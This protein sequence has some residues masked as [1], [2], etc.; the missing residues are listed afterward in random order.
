MMRAMF[1]AA[2]TFIA[3]VLFVGCAETKTTPPVANERAALL[4]SADQ[5]MFGV[6]FNL[7]DGG[8][9]KGYVVADTAVFLN[10]NTRIELFNATVTFYNTT[11]AN[12]AVMSARYGTYHTQ[13]GLMVGRGD[14]DVKTED[15]RTLRS[16]EVKFDQRRNEISSDSAFVVTAPDRRLEGIGFRSDPNLQNVRV[17]KATSGSSGSV[18]IPNQ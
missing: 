8:I 10:S 5:V 3:A 1:L 11:G 9:A 17:L 7:T 2:S 15:G 12:E 6:R 4:D 16:P 18:T 14:V 13:S